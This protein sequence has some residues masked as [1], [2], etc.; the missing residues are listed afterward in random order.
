MNRT[1]G[2]GIPRELTGRT[3]MTQTKR[4][5]LLSLLAGLVV[6]ILGACGDDAASEPVIEGAWA[7]PGE[8]GDNSA[9]YMEISNDGDDDI[10]LVGASGDVAEVV[11][12]HESRMEDGMM[13]MGEVDEVPV[14]A[15]ETVTLQP[16]EF[17]VMMMNLNEDLE[18]GDTF[19]LA[20]EFEG[21]DDVEVDV[22][23]E[24]Q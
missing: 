17:H 20:M 3:S 4:R 15:G 8:A 18:P 12:V 14:P 16:G 7:R 10:S 19:T 23:V 6:V 9:A 13:K 11:E 24:E 21:L 5:M 22:T 1:V 2:Y